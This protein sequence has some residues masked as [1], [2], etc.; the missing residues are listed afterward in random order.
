MRECL[1]D[2]FSTLWH[3]FCRA[4]LTAQPFDGMSREELE[5]L[6]HGPLF[7]S[8]EVSLGSTRVGATREQIIN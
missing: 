3:L 2:A 7:G 5:E 4:G 8:G 6:V 1:Q